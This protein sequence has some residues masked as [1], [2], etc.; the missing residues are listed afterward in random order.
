MA[1]L[2]KPVFYSSQLANCTSYNA[3]K[4]RPKV[5]GALLF[6]YQRL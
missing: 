1:S 5:N 2:A 3:K 4:Q 6:E